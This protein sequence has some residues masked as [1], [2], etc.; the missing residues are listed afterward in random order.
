MFPHG[1]LSLSF[2]WILMLKKLHW[3]KLAETCFCQTGLNQFT[4]SIDWRW[5]YFRLN[6]KTLAFLMFRYISKAT[7]HWQIKKCGRQH[8]SGQSAWISLHKLFLLMY[9]CKKFF[10][11]FISFK[12]FFKHIVVEIFYLWCRGPWK[13]LEHFQMQEIYYYFVI[14]F[15]K[16]IFKHNVVEILFSSILCLKW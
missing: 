16:F 4:A 7:T 14:S 10:I 2:L 12:K 13:N 15:K 5:W 6:R 9:G 3:Q 1:I 8:G 11:N